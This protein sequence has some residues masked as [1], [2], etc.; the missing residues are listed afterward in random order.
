MTFSML[1]AQ[2]QGMHNRKKTKSKQ[3]ET[4]KKA[5]TTKN[6]GFIEQ[7]SEGVVKML[8]YFITIVFFFRERLQHVFVT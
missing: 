5:E 7:S 2:R 6:R 3:K 4:E 8:F 1:R